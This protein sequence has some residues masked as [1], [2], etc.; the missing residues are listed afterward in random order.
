MPTLHFKP[1]PR[2]IL[3]FVASICW[4]WSARADDIVNDTWL[5]GTRTDPASPTYS[6]NGV[7]IDDDGNLESAWYGG[8]TATYTVSPSN[9][10]MGIG[11]SSASFTT[12]YTPEAN[13]VTLGSAGDSMK[14][15]WH[16]KPNNVNASNTS[17][18]FRL[19]VVD[20]PTRLTSDGTPGSAAYVGYAVF[21][22]MC[23]TLANAN[24][25]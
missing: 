20:S 14:I 2:I 18:N 3:F 22:N 12:Y 8:N 10:V 7:D 9:L 6:E 15:T 13:P 4:A 16:F 23:Q 24:P 5:D 1:I 21:M 19:G 25:F 11:A 17:Q